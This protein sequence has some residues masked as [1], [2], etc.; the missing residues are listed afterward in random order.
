[1]QGDLAG[2][3]AQFGV[4]AAEAEAAHDEI[5]EGVSASRARASHSHTRVRRVR[6]GPRPRR[7]SRPPRSL[8]GFPRASAYAA[9]AIAAL[10]AGDVAAAQDASEAAWQHLSVLPAT[11]AMQRAC[12][13]QAALAGGDL[14]RGPPLGRR[15]RRDDDRLVPDRGR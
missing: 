12:S 11:A 13:A 14:R 3:V 9:L 10:A 5:C 4:V 2:A 6:P 15:R 7:P 1:M 8:A